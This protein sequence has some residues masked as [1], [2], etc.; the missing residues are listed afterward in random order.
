MLKK[1]TYVVIGSF[2][3]GAL[4]LI[5]LAQWAGGG[6]YIFIRAGQILYALMTIVFGVATLVF[7]WGV[8]QYVIA[9]GDEKKGDKARSYMM[10]GII[11]LAVMAGVWGFVN[12][13]LVTLFNGTGLNAPGL[14]GFLGGG[15]QLEQNECQSGVDSTGQT[16]QCIGQAVDDI[17]SL[18]D[19]F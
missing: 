7:L 15:N 10:Y 13:L 14:P 2:S 1:T 19:S 11:G 4:P 18:I 3:L 12:L 8:I 9:G 16:I 17:E 6:N 5:A